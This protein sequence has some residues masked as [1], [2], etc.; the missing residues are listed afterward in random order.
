MYTLEDIR[1]IAI[2]IECNGE[3]TYRTVGEKAKNPEL[4]HILLWLADEEKRHAT[5]FETLQSGRDVSEADGEMEAM[6]RSLLRDMV[7]DQP[8]SLDAEELEGAADVAE[9]VTQS[10]SFEQD[11]VLFYDM[12]KSLLVEDTKTV[13]QLNI[14]IEEERGHVRVLEKLKKKFVDGLDV[15]LSC[16]VP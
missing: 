10:L 13:A 6:G 4:A 1:D 5:W 12:L 8:F 11:T 9:I 14:I 16:S 2:Q 3:K 7:K 15:D